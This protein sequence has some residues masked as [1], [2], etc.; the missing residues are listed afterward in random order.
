MHT[1]IHAHTQI[2]LKLGR[3]GI[4]GKESITTNL[5][6]AKIQQMLPGPAPASK[7]SPQKLLQVE[8]PYSNKAV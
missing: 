8:S 4:F 5:K 7:A 6:R 3:R 1:C 2:N